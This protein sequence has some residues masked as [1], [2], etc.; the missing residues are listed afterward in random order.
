MPDVRVRVTPLLLG[1]VAL[2]DLMCVGVPAFAQA[3]RLEVLPVMFIPSDRRDILASA[4]FAKAKTLVLQH[5][6]LAQ[7]HYRSLLQTDTF[8]ISDRGVV[9]YIS[10]KP[11]AAYGD[12]HWE[13]IR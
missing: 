5:L 8:R 12:G 6:R 9:V 11:A 4:E 7:T 1:L 2:A 13:E 10:P 3:N